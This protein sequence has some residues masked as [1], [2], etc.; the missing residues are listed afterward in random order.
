MKLLIKLL[1]IL[2]LLLV[3]A[4]SQAKTLTVDS[5]GKGDARTISGAMAL[6]SSGDTIVVHPGEYSGAVIDRSVY[7]TSSLT[8]SGQARVRGSLVVAA[9]GCQ[10]SGLAIQGGEG[11][12]ALVLKSRDNVLIRCTV[13]GGSIGIQVIAS[14]NTILESQIDCPVGLEITGPGCRA[15]N[16]TFQGETGI[17]LN[18]SRECIIRGCRIAAV[19]GVVVDSSTKNRIEE[20]TFT[21]MGFGVVLSGSSANQV[22]NNSLSGDYVSGVDVVDSS[23]NNLS[24][25]NITGGKLGISLRRSHGN[26]LARNVCQNNERAGIYG[27]GSSENLIEQNE[28]SRN[29]NGILLSASVEN[30]L[31]SNRAA[32][33]TYGISL[34]GCLRNVLRN[35]SLAGNAYSLR[36]D[37]GE[38]SSA[39]LAA[40]SHDFFIQEIDGSNLADGRPVCYLVGSRDREI[41][42]AC[43]FLAVVSCRNITVRNQSISNSSTGVLMVNATA[44][45]V[46]NSTVAR[47]E[48]GFLLQDCSGWQVAES[49]ASGCLIGFAAV[50]SADGLFYRDGAADCK[51]EGFR[52]NG[53]LN[54]SIEECSADAC[55]RGIVL[56]DARLCTVQNCSVIGN[57]D[58]GIMATRSERCLFKDNT[59]SSN[60]RGLSL[61]GGSG[62]VLTGNAATGNLRD[63]ISLEQLTEAVVR[64]N[65]ALMNAQGIFVQ[66][67]QRLLIE[68]NNLSENSRFGL[69]MSSSIGCNITDNIIQRNQIAG[70]NLVDC[71]DSL[72]YHNIFQDNGFQNA[73]DNGANQWDGGPARG[74]NYW[75]DHRVEGDPGSTPRQIPT[76]GVDRYPFQ[77]PGGWL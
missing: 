65:A 38:E 7:L 19:Q 71:T 46:E 44:C 60:T 35:N 30:A 74:G 29:G 39:T 62:C 66:S 10:I 48:K 25:N 3:A 1:I 26:H 28:L 23:E 41:S 5:G 11:S 2:S 43:G 12:P 37:G 54:Q 50:G 61:S 72:L 67:S 22:S 75:S 56:Q 49:R 59:A 36:V 32:L 63:G 8:G 51:E 64:G 17:R 13:A 15:F 70:A 42:Y 73:A 31:L 69:R 52:L 6:A 53:P 68:K 33:N 16:S 24:G 27:D 9:P 21:G 18:E 57:E 47:A 20:N 14:N 77:N 55:S 45:R 4:S 58:A 40:S 34:R 76:K